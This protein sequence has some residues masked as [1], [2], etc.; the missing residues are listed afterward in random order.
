MD[1][2][3]AR[4][5]YNAIQAGRKRFAE[6]LPQMVQDTMEPEALFSRGDRGA[7]MGVVLD[8]KPA[9]WIPGMGRKE[10]IMTALL[11]RGT[12]IRLMGGFVI[13]ASLLLKQLADNSKVAEEFGWDFEGTLEGNL[14]KL[15]AIE[16][17]PNKKRELIGLVLGYPEKAIRDYVRG[18]EL[19]D[20]GTP[21][22]YHFFNY[23]LDIGAEEKLHTEN[24][25]PADL[26]TLEEFAAWNKED[27]KRIQGL[28]ANERYAAT[29]E[30][31]TKIQQENAERLRALYKKYF[32]ASAEDADFL[33]SLHAVSINS[34]QGDPVY[35]Y[36]ES[37][38]GDS[39]E[40]EA[41][42]QRVG[43][44]FHEVGL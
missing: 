44:A 41:L 6:K 3:E 13:N 2:N 38:Q 16:Q 39:S 42:R 14:A 33:M 20:A 32:N 9:A 5:E 11:K 26:Q 40:T 30:S 10:A 15:T 21:N 4:A 12:N 35:N 29:V 28:P 18:Q 8:A 34:P 7:L 27:M 36:M 22:S 43:K 37:S 1:Q 23:G 19:Q 24:W 25:E 31:R 17:G